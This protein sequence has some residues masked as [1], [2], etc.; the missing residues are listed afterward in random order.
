MECAI[1]T[2]YEAAGK[3]YIALLPL[4]ENGDN[5]T[6]EVYL[7]R[8]TEEDG[9]PSLDNIEDDEE[10]EAA[11]DGFDQWLDEQE[12]NELVFEDD[13]EVEELN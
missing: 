5:E 6:G 1:L 13:E 12:Y 4:N 8:Y 2:I 7:Y 3:D 10:Y 9:Q 11:S